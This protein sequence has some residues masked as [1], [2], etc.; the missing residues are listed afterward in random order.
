M[1]F[2]LP[3]SY[4]FVEYLGRNGES[5]PDKKNYAYKDYSSFSVDEDFTN[6]TVPQE[7]GSRADTDWFI[8]S[9]KG[10]V[11]NLRNIKISSDKAFSFSVLPYSTLELNAAA[12]NW[13]LGKSKKNTV[14]VDYKMSGV[15][16]NSCG[17]ELDERYRLSEKKIDFSFN[18]E[19]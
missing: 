12:H 1:E 19:F 16:S 4:N 9:D 7:C 10:A 5:Y 3:E 15:G 8:V 17:P 14:C 13:Q 6:Y 2:A 11:G 18:I